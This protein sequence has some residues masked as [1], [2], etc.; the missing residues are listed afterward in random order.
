MNNEKERYVWKTVKNDYFSYACIYDSL[1]G[2]NLYTNELVLSVLNQQD[3]Y[4]KE[5]EKAKK[6]EIE[7][8]KNYDC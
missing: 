3:K 7:G 5:L 2:R 8:G 6:L 1:D 4:I